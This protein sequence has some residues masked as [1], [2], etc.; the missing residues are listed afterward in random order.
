MKTLVTF[1][2][3][4]A[5]RVYQ[6]LQPF[7]APLDPFLSSRLLSRQ[8]KYAMH[9]LSR[10]I[11]VEVL[12]GLER[13]MRSRTKDSWGSSFCAFLVLC[14]CMEGLQIA[15]DIYVVCDMEKCQK[16]GSSSAYNRTQSYQASMKVDENPFSQCKR[17]FHDIYR[18]HKESNR[19]AREAGFNP[20]KSL[21]MNDKNTGLDSAGDAMAKSIY[22]M[23]CQSCKVTR[24]HIRKNEEAD[25]RRS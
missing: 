8:I 22:R 16:D 24:I 21:A 25:L 23:I 4:S 9:K 5:T 17:L 15:C 18:S 10:E 6:T 7:G 1:S 3:E 12:E 20:L 2:E 14:L 11:T 19:G 13:S